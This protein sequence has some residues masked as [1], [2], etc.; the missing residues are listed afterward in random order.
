MKKSKQI[1]A[2]IAAGYS[3]KEE[4]AVVAKELESIGVVVISKWHKERAKP[5]TSLS[6]C[7]ESFLRRNAKKDIREL[8]E[9]N[10]FVMLSVN[11]DIPFKRGGS[12]VENGFAIAKGLPVL[13]IGPKQH[14]FHYLPGVKRVDTIEQAKRWL[15]R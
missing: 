8:T 9:A 6:D 12:C 2:Y 7:T 3:R 1:K 11:P 15:Q 4:V 5:Q 14:I 10:Y 13:V